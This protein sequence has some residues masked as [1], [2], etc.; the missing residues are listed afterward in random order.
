MATTVASRSSSNYSSTPSDDESLEQHTPTE[1]HL[2]NLSKTIIHLLNTRQ[3]THPFFYSHV[4]QNVYV[5]LDGR[6]TVGLPF[7]LENHKS[8]AQNSSAFY[9]D[10]GFNVTALAD[11]EAGSATV[12]LSQHLSGFGGNMSGMARAGTIL[13]SW[14]KSKGRWWCSNATMI[15]G[16]PEFLL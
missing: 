8:D 3:Y 1:T 5:A 13:F 10:V 11:E 7:F 4:R 16:T 6:G 2:I 15:Y 14:Q 12:I 9:V